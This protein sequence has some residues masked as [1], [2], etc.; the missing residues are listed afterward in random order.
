MDET[1][2]QKNEIILLES[3]SSKLTTVP[4][5]PSP[6]SSSASWSGKETGP[7]LQSCLALPQWGGMRWESDCLSPSLDGHPQ[8][9]GNEFTFCYSFG[10]AENGVWCA[11]SLVAKMC[12]R[13]VHL[14]KEI[15]QLWS[16]PSS[17][18]FSHKI[19]SKKE[20]RGLYTQ[21]E[22]TNKKNFCCVIQIDFL[23]LFIFTSWQCNDHDKMIFTMSSEIQC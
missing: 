15:N 2:A 13:L 5:A 8:P 3:V 1:E 16:F 21:Q 19:F 22:K 4:V 6:L 10:G 9:T 20:G 14:Y 18:S 23:L 7:G 11:P 17:P 12:K